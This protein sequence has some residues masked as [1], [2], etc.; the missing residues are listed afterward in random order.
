[1]KQM[2]GKSSAVLKGLELKTG[3]KGKRNEKKKRMNRRALGRVW[4]WGCEEG[5]RHGGDGVDGAC[6]RG[7][8]PWGLEGWSEGRAEMRDFWRGG[9]KGRSPCFVAFVFC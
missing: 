4:R 6:G 7:E 5:R 2:R 3:R 8:R 9:C 1:M